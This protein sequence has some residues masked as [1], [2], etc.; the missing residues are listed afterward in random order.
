MLFPTVTALYAVIFAL[1]YFALTAWVIAG[2]VTFRVNLGDGGQDL[3]NRRIRAHGNFAE[4]IPFILLLAALLEGKGAAPITLHALLLPLVIARLIHPVGMLAP[5]LSSRQFALRG[6]G[7]VITAA[8]L[9]I[10]ALLL[11]TQLL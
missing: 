10:T 7:M 9:L 4:Y 11:L 6:V 5:S 1:I 2:R 3:L 8:I